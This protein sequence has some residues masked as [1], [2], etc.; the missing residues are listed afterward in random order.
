MRG[1]KI[2]YGALI[3]FLLILPITGI[4]YLGQ[5]ALDAP[6]AP[7]DVFNWMSG[8]LPGPIIT[9]G[10][11]MMINTLRFLGISVASASKTSEQIMAIG[12]FTMLGIIGGAAYFGV[13]SS[14]RIKNN[15]FTGW[16]AA[17]IFGGPVMAISLSMADSNYPPLTNFVWLGVFFLAWG[18]AIQSLYRRIF[19]YPVKSQMESDLT[20]E[21]HVHRISRRRFLIYLGG[22]TAAI[23]VIGAGLGRL[24]GQEGETDSSIGDGS[25]DL[26]V[27]FPNQGDPVQPVPGTRPEYTPVEDHYQVFIKLMPTEIDGASWRLPIRG[28]VDNPMMLTI[29]DLRNN[30]EPQHQFVTLRCIS[31]RIGTSLI[32]TTLWTGASLQKVLADAGLQETARYLIVSSGDGYYETID[33]DLVESEPRIMLA[34]NWDGEPIPTDHGFP[35][36]VWIP[37]LYGMKQPKWIT[38]IEVTDTYQD[39]YWVERGWDK[40]A[41]VNTTSVIDTVAVDSIIERNGQEYIPVGGIAYSGGR[42]VSK[43]EIRVDDGPWE[44]AQLRKPLS[45]TTWVLWRYEWPYQEGNHTFSVRCY[46]GDGTRQIMEKTDIRPDGVTGI[47]SVKENI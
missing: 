29:E 28:M 30:Y 3:G 47:H 24:V 1:K 42:G 26:P 37:D 27:P 21:P 45:E 15:P 9:F 7:F 40:E 22:T 31:G 8:I 19:S 10:I 23:T 25:Q 11:D 43:V 41:R 2:L 5:Q 16:I 18:W 39:G 35:L 38:D 12:L 13:I 17:A 6:F 34:Y 20:K 4:M 33:L 32:S 46:D 36:R 44:E 14:P